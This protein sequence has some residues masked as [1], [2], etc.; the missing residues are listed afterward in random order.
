MMIEPLRRGDHESE[1]ESE[2]ASASESEIPMG[3]YYLNP[4]ESSIG[5]N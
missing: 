2:N 4:L 5:R 3:S 1:S